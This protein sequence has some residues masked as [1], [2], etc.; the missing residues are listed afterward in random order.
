MQVDKLFNLVNPL[1]AETTG[2]ARICQ[3]VFALS[4]R[5]H[6]SFDL[7]KL[8]R[9]I[10]VIPRSVYQPRRLTAE[11]MKAQMGATGTDS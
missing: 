10:K 9:R 8:L 3:I 1:M 2:A 5:R 7:N 6:F 11:Q 4:A